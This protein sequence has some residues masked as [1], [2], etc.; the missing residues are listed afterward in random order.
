V[1][2]EGTVSLSDGGFE[3]VFAAL[4]NPFLLVCWSPVSFTNITVALSS[5]LST[6]FFFTK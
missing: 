3:W 6:D 4:F 1:S 5:Q 2:D